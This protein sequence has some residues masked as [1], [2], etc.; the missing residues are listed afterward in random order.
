M[1][2]ADIDSSS[3]GIWIDVCHSAAAKM[4]LVLHLAEARKKHI[5]FAFLDMLK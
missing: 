3:E 1:D 4:S 2:L 5:F